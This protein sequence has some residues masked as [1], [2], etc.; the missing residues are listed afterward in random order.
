MNLIEKKEKIIE[1]FARC[2]DKRL[3]YKKVR[4]TEE[5][6]EIL[7]QDQDFQDRMLFFLIERREALIQQMY[8][9]ATSANEKISLTA[10]IELGKMI[11]PE[12][13]RGGIMDDDKTTDAD[14]AVRFFNEHSNK[15]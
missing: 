4:L 11:Y 6:A 14:E 1:S 5:E 8:N 13:F 7:D 10:T 12:V 15:S 3:A 2:L 9:H